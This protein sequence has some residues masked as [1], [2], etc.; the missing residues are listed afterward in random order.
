MRDLV[1]TVLPRW[2]CLILVAWG[3]RTARH[4]IQHLRWVLKALNACVDE[5]QDT[6]F[7]PC[8]GCPCMRSSSVEG[9]VKEMKEDYAAVIAEENKLQ[10]EAEGEV[11]VDI[12]IKVG[13]KGPPGGMG[14]KGYEGPDGDPGATGPQG[15]TGPKGPIG[16]TGQ[17]P[18]PPPATFP[19]PPSLSLPPLVPPPLA[20]HTGVGR[21]NRLAG[22]HQRQISMDLVLLNFLASRPALLLLD[23]SFYTIFLYT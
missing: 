10:K 17:P 21:P 19:F 11:P 2:P 3:D 5:P 4:L 15:P 9:K 12:T 13:P 20:L 18:P 8:A 7:G 14:P 16:E 23:S 22:T 6:F 1:F